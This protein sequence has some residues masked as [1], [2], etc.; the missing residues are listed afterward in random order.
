MCDKP[1]PVSVS[2]RGRE[3]EQDQSRESLETL[4]EQEGAGEHRIA[5][6]TRWNTPDLDSH[7]FRSMSQHQ[8][9]SVSVTG[10]EPSRAEH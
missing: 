5:S 2:T 7:L 10:T 9:R 8:A 6:Q 4:G 1:P 3:Y